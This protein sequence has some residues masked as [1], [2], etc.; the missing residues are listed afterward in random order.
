M[1]EQQH[2]IGKYV[3]QGE[4][5]RGGMGVVY[6]ALDPGIE[7]RVAIKTVAKNLLDASE[8]EDVM[9]RFKREAQ[10]AGRLTHPNI[11]AV[12]DAGTHDG[13]GF[14]AME[15]VR[16]TTLARWLRDGQPQEEILAR[17]RAHERRDQRVH[18]RACDPDLVAA[19][20]R[21]ARGRAPVIRLFVA[22]R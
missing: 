12:F 21:G 11:V 4:L 2:L 19:A 14:V 3:V 16:G 18:H 17:F 9:A 13:R 6:A 5:G 8:A 1:R 22:G 7:R 20:G 10:A 15:L